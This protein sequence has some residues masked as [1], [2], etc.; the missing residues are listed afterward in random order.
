MTLPLYYYEWNDTNGPN[1]LFH[2]M[3]TFWPSLNLGVSVSYGIFFINSFIR[4]LTLTSICASIEIKIIQK[5]VFTWLAL[6]VKFYLFISEINNWCLSIPVLSRLH[7]NI[8]YMYLAPGAIL[9]VSLNE[10]TNKQRSAK[11]VCGMLFGAILGYG[12][13]L[14]EF[15]VQ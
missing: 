6:S 15:M 3:C 4:N 1:F 5:I 12:M 11:H 9:L 14:F 8:P 13:L 7:L 2:S 10:W